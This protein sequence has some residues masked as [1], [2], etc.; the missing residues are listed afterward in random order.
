MNANTKKVQFVKIQSP[1]TNSH[2]IAI[3]RSGG[4]NG[5]NLFGASFLIALL[6]G[7]SILANLANQSPTVGS[8]AKNISAT[9]TN[10]EIL[11]IAFVAG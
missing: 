3:A 2:T 5:Y 1:A 4:S 8:G 9:G 11:N 7:Q 10:T 6:P